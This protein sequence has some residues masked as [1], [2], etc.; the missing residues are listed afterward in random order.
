MIFAGGPRGP[1][2]VERIDSVLGEPL[3]G[4]D[5]LSMLEGD[6]NPPPD[7]VWV[8]RGVTAEERYTTR[9]E[10][11]ALLSLQQP[12]GRA[13]ATRAAP[14]PVKKSAAWWSLSQDERRAI[15]EERSRH[16][17]TGLEYLPA[18]ARRLHHCREL[19]GPFD[20]L[21]WFEYPRSAAAAFED[22][23]RRLRATDEWR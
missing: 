16:V 23:V 12:L 10:H 11:E 6:P 15:F 8:L 17:S 1:W 18:V 7:A 3:D 21:T 13:E 19:G 5:C 4:V 22:L 14:I 2:R 9:V 20:F